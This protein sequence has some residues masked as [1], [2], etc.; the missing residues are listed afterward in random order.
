MKLS[1]PTLY[2]LTIVLKR[3]S[4]LT[5]WLGVPEGQIHPERLGYH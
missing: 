4:A 5:R 2:N 1:F 3:D